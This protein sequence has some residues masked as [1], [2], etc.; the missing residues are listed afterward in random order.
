MHSRRRRLLLIPLVLSLTLGA[1]GPVAA[2]G[3]LGSVTAAPR[4]LKF[5]RTA[6]GAYSDRLSVWVTNSTKAPLVVTGMALSGRDQDDFIHGLDAGVTT[7]DCSFR[8]LY[9]E[10][11]APGESCGYVV[12]FHPDETGQ[13]AATLTLS[14]SDGVRRFDA[15]VGLSGTGT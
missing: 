7:F 4:S 11:L 3:G 12:A 1:V 2:G 6:I 15:S 14:F 9:G 5:A 8:L 13:H 10:L